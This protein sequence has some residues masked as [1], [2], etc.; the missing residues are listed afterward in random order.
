M[1]DPLDVGLEHRVVVVD[2]V[3]RASV[4]EPER[5]GEER[6]HLGPGDVAVRA[7]PRVG[8]RVASERDAGMGDPLDVGLELRAV[9][10]GEGDRPAALQ[11]ERPCQEGRHLASSH[12]LEVAEP[13]VGR[14]IASPGDAGGLDPLDVGLEDRTVVIAERSV[15]HRVVAVGVEEDLGHPPTG[16]VDVGTEGHVAPVR[17]EDVGAVTRGVH[18]HVVDLR[19]VGQA[20]VGPPGDVLAVGE[21]LGRQDLSALGTRGVPEGVEAH[22]L[23]PGARL[24]GAI[25][26]PDQRVSAGGGAILV[27][28]LDQ[29]GLELV[30]RHRAGIGGGRRRKAD[31]ACQ[32]DG[33]HQRAQP[34]MRCRCP[35]L[36]Q[37]GSLL[38][39][40]LV[41]ATLRIH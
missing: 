10:V 18:E 32:H 26:G 19:A 1:G 34:A 37:E 29:A 25:D 7:E 35:S 11:V 39:Q 4:A 28:L 31:D 24:V 14:W 23:R 22:P 9:V 33:R 41:S 15:A 21:G 16:A 3:G 5:S 36:T 6:R 13:V 2:E 27:D 30:G 17:A 40:S 8:R 38:D 20:V 12:Q